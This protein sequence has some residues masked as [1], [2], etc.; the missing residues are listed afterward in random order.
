MRTHF[1]GI[2]YGLAATL[3]FSS[4]A[5]AQV[6]GPS[7]EGR[8]SP[9][10]MKAAAAAPKPAYD[11]HDLSGVWWGAVGRTP[12]TGTILQGNPIPPLTP[13]GQKL[14]DANKPSQGPRRVMPA[15]GND[16][17]GY[18]DPLGYPRNLFQNR[19][20][21]QFIQTPHEVLQ[22][23]EWNF[24]VRQIFTDGRKIP[25]DADP[26]WFGYAVGHWDGNTFVV[27]ST[28][29]IDKT[30]LDG[31]GDPHTEDMKLE[32]RW[33]HPDAMTLQVTMTLTDPKIYTKPWVSAK[34]IVFDLQLPKGLTELREEY[35]VPSEEESF[36]EHTRDRAAGL[37]Q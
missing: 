4:A 1:I 36:N 34:P 11:P 21:F 35:C 22:L 18:C 8:R 27:D 14:L 15:L 5:F 6:Y 12:T 37:P 7:T 30:W 23:F 29:Y 10:D 20:P 33:V 2:A 9:A 19:R 28:D 25:P 31:F 32:E 16:P 3:L 13:Y 24:A 17:L 26:R